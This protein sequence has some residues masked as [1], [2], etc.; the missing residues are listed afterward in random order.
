MWTYS[1]TVCPRADYSRLYV[2]DHPSVND[3]VRPGETISSSLY[4]RRPGGK[5]ANQALAV[6]R[7]GGHGRVDLVGCIGPDPDGAWVTKFL[8]ENG[9]NVEGVISVSV[10]RSYAMSLAS[11][12]SSV[13]YLFIG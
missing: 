12:S 1:F 2:P 11:T 4:E 10:V 3:I 13:F 5:G 9:V 7:A 6:S 8:S